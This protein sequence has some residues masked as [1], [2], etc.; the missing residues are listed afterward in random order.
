M[1]T[2]LLPQMEKE[3]GT[4]ITKEA[5]IIHVESVYAYLAVTILSHHTQSYR[6]WGD[7]RI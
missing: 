2:G 7:R 1:V 3:M 4:Q 6:A 5:N